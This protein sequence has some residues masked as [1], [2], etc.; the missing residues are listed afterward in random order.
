MGKSYKGSIP[1]VPSLVSLFL[2]RMDGR[3]PC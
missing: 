1:F 3:V 2:L